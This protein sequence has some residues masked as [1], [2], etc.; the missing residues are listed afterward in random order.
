MISK[1]FKIFSASV[2]SLGFSITI[3]GNYD[4]KL[5]DEQQNPR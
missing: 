3:I 5:Y 4:K 1:T 2:F